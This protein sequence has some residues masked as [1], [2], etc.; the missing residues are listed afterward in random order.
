LDEFRELIKVDGLKSANDFRYFRRDI[1]DPAIKQINE[2]S[3]IDISLE[4]R[5]TGRFYSHLRFVISTSRNH[6]LLTSIS[7]S[8][9]L[10]LILTSEFGLSDAELDE[11]A[12]NRETWPDDRLRDAIEFVRH[13]CTTSK[14]LYPAKYLMTAIRDGYRVGSIERE[15]NKPKVVKKIAIADNPRPSIVLPT[16]E[17][18]TDAWTLFRQSPQAKL[19][20]PVAEHFELAT[21]QQKKAFEGFLQSQ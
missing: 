17:A 5:R 11:I 7:A 9:E 8:K 2:T 10:Y 14:V 21:A 13:R 6:L 3:D 1:I 20:K 18:L 16:G 19:F 15:A 12:K 4:L